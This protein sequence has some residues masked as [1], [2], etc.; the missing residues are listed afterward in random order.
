MDLSEFDFHLPDELI[1]QEAELTRD[2]ARLM[3]L[4]RETGEIAHH[5]VRNVVDLLKPCLLYTSDAADE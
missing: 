1:A 4:D 5:R 3:S 2:A